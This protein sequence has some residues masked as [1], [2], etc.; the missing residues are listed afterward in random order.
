ML[1]HCDCGRRYM[2]ITQL[3]DEFESGFA[4][5]LCERR[6]GEWSG[7]LHYIFEPESE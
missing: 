3:R 1:V 5:C 4:L 7:P 6:L 2:R